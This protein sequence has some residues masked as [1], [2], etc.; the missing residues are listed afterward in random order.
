MKKILV[1][2]DIATH[3][4]TGGNNQCIMQYVAC[5]RNIGFDVYYLL[6]GS[7]ELSARSIE[8]TKAFW[9]ERFFYYR[10]PWWQSCYMKVYK[11]ITRQAYPDNID[12]YSPLGIVGF[13]NR[14][15]KKYDFTGIVVNYIWQSRLAHCIIPIKAIFTHDVFTYRNERIATGNN[16]H[17]HSAKEEARGVR[18]FPNI[19]AIQDIE[20]SYFSFLSPHSDVWSVY[21][22]FTFVEQPV[23]GNKNILFFSGNN[24]LNLEAIKCFIDQVF[25]QLLSFDSEVRLLL[26]GN[27]CSAFNLQ[28]LPPNI[29]LKGRYENPDDFYLLGD[30]AIN[31]VSKGTGLKIKTFEAIAHGK[32]TITDPHSALGIYNA[33]DAPLHIAHSPD[34]YIQTIL[35]FIHRPQDITRNQT[36]CRGYINS[37]N[38]YITAQYRNI[39][40]PQ[41]T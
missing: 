17:H 18:R 14:L 30:I 41:S 31:P 7:N 13:V 37:L 15:H 16:W 22:N 6:I 36:L 23:T 21:S 11:H 25:M 39:F 1:A 34:E 35:Q 26:G 24:G 5:L 12:F 32:V 38:E 8:E 2:A 3:P 9:G 29:E 33:C 27:I 10:F 20:R 4:C 28:E 40:D 19:L